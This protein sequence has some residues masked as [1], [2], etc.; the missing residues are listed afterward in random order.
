MYED[1]V[2]KRITQ[3]RLSRGV[4]ARDMSLSLGQNESYINRIE[5]KKTLPSDGSVLYLRVFSHQSAGVFRY[6]DTQ[7]RKSR[8]AHR[9][10]KI[11]YRRAA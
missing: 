5:N 3:L 10:C 2:P 6:R 7:P 4:S 8:A 1:F 11:T 9:M